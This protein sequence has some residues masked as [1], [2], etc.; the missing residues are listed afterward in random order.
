A[1]ELAAL[2]PEEFARRRKDRAGQLWTAAFPNEAPAEY[3]NDAFI[4]IGNVGE[5]RLKQVGDWAHADAEVLRRVFKVKESLIWRGK[6]IIFVFKDRF[7]Y[8]EFAQTNERVEIPPET[9]GHARVTASEDEAYIALHDIGDGATEES[10]GIRTLLMALMTE[11]L[12]QRSPN[13]V[14]DWAARGTGLALAGRSDRKS[15]YFRGLIAGAHD[16]LRVVAKPEEIFAN[17]TFSSGDLTPVGY[18]LVTH[19]MEKGG[20]PHFVQFL[21]LLSSGKNLDEALR[22]VFATDRAGLAGSY[23]AYVGSLPG[24]KV[25]TKKAKK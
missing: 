10:P 11:G 20:E 5:A 19:M 1:K 25:G 3:E 7:S 4:A 23:W 17:D 6:L 9:K 2:S 24:A 15:P 18:T 21:N 22:D 16:A 14:P 13:K 12:L 8:T